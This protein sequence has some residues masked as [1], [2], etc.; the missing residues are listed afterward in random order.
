MFVLDCVLQPALFASHE[1]RCPA[2]TAGK[3]A[4]PHK[5]DGFRLRPCFL[6]TLAPHHMIGC[7]KDVVWTRDTGIYNL[8]FLENEFPKNHRSKPHKGPQPGSD[9]ATKGIDGMY[10]SRGTQWYIVCPYLT[11]GG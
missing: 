6:Y 4:N 7:E 2:Q 1:M 8:D 10:S 3:R 5:N 9:M 11:I